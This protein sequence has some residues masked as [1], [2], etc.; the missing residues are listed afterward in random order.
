MRARLVLLRKPR[1]EGSVTMWERALL[2]VLLVGFVVLL[3]LDATGGWTY[4]LA[5]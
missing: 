2:V 5:P 1:P 4:R 3:T